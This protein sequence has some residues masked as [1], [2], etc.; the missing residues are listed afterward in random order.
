[1]RVSHFIK[2]ETERHRA[3]GGGRDKKKGKTLIQILSREEKGGEEL[4]VNGRIDPADGDGEYL[5]STGEKE[6][7]MLYFAYGSNLD[8]DQM[9]MRCPSA[10]FVGIAELRD[11]RLAFTRRSALRGCGVSDV[12]PEKGQSVWGVVYEIHEKDVGSLDRHE[13]YQ[14]ERPGGKNCY[15]RVEKHVYPPDSQTPWCVFTYKV[16][17]REDH[18]PLPSAEYRNLIIRGAEYWHLPAWHIKALKENK[19]AH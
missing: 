12:V 16:A 5:L 3:R 11:H 4:A 8:W 10:R 15:V 7:T 9:R 2:C 18:P 6:R 17:N 1:V 14:P 13:G 19:V